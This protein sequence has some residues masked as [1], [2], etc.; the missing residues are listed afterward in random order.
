MT[1]GLVNIPAFLVK[2]C[3]RIFAQ[4]L[5][6]LFNLMLKSGRFPA[7]WKISR[8]CPIFKKDHKNDIKLHI[9]ILVLGNILHK[10][11]YN[12]VQKL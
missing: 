3:S 1:M 6:A 4:P 7:A 2:D 9:G 10:Y 8:I 5:A 11:I 12:H